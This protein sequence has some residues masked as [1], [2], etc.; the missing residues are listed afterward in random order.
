MDV[1]C[2]KQNQTFSYDEFKY[3][4]DKLWKLYYKPLIISNTYQYCLMIIKQVLSCNPLRQIGVFRQIN[5]DIVLQ[6]LI[7]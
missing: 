6:I 3:V 1:I 7:M 2:W 5:L 4:V